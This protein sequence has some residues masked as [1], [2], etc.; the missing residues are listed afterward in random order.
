[1][2]HDFVGIVMYDP[3]MLDFAEMNRRE[4]LV[5]KHRVAW[6]DATLRPVQDLRVTAWQQTL[7]PSSIARFE[8]MA[9]YHLLSCGYAL[10]ASRLG[11]YR[12][13]NTFALYAA[14]FFRK[15]LGTHT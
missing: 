5:P 1:M 14:T 2:F 13:V 3:V 9:G 15:L 10:Q 4:E 8:L 6:H 12:A 7:L 11:R